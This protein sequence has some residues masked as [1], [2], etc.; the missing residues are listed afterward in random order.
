MKNINRVFLFGDS[1]I[2]GQGTYSEIDT[3]GTN[4]ELHEPNIPFGEDR[5]FGMDEK[6]IS[7]WRKKNSWNLFFKEKYG[8]RDSQII[9]YGKQGS[10][11]YSMFEKFN[12]QF[13]SFEN[14]DLIL[15]GF[16][17]KYRDSNCAIQFAFKHL[18]NQM[19]PIINRLSFEKNAL[20]G[21]ENDDINENNQLENELPKIEKEVTKE[22]MRDHMISVFDET[23]HEN[24]AQSNY[25]FYE[26]WCKV[27]D[28]N[29][30]FFDLFEPYVDRKFVSELYEVDKTMYITYDEKSY[31]QRL[32]E[33]ELENYKSDA[34]YSIW[35]T[36]HTFPTDSILH[37][38]QHGY[39]V[40]FD[41]I[42]TNHVD[43][44]YTFIKRLI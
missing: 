13:D 14:T 20:V 9:N 37:P 6:T 24:V 41:D 30:L 12:N 33:Y 27:H 2:E 3:H 22:Y 19:N 32:V 35:E 1:W 31:N 42:T 15:F 34:K 40:I 38:N 23:V 17:S 43:T 44:K 25:L 11:N 18:L 7:G 28:I 16:T 4:T 26:K 5:G 10:D 29:I 8:L 39:K 21:K 36:G